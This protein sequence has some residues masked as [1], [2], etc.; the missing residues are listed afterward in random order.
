MHYVH[1]QTHLMK[2]LQVISYRTHPQGAMK[3]G[4]RNVG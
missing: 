3:T 4:C 2:G 1:Y